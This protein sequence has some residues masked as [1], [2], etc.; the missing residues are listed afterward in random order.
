M[1]QNE[2]AVELLQSVH[3]EQPELQCS[4]KAHAF[5]VNFHHN[6]QNS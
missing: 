5:A 1:Y 2:S 3:Y 6:S 4:S